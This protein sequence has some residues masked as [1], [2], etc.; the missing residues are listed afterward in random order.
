[1]ERA[2]ASRETLANMTIGLAQRGPGEKNGVV[3]LLMV[4]LQHSA[5]AIR[6]AWI[7]QTDG[8]RT[9]RASTTARL[10]AAHWSASANSVA[11]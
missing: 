7:C 2:V 1:M 10:D 8:D 6:P 3:D 4:V 5:L 11:Q 9:T